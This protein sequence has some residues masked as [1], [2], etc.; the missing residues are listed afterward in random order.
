MKL[1]I[2]TPS[3]N[4]P[5]KL[6]GLFNSIKRAVKQMPQGN[7]AEW[8]IIDDG[9][10]ED[11]SLLIQKIHPVDHL[12]IRCIRQNNSGK[13]AAFNRAIEM[14]DGDLFVCIDDDDRLSQNAVQDIFFL[15]DK[16]LKD[17]A[18]QN[19][20]GFAGRVIDRSGKKKGK[21]FKS[22]P[23]VSNTIEIRD[24]HHF[25]GEPEIYFV[26]RL[27]EYRFP[28]FAQEKFLTEA[29]VFDE[30]TAKHPLI[31]TDCVMMIKTF[32]KGGLT[33][34]Q[35]KIRIES[36]R[37]TEDYYY[38]RSRLCKEK[39]YRLKSV[40]N[41]QRFSYWIKDMRPQRAFD[42]YEIVARPVSLF[43]YFKDFLQYNLQNH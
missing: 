32:L 40:I 16:F 37:G 12:T 9:S 38:R 27:K 5:Q 2:F 36:P 15:A 24:M 13:H 28:V 8:L 6:P 21:N 30:L 11:I 35:L 18:Y 1:T 20:S 22:Y 7:T 10:D 43:M 4:R 23:V 33:D 19:C 17:A 14:C 3:Y 34:Q 31:Y 29:Y 41:R 39:R 25:W 42:Q 26:N